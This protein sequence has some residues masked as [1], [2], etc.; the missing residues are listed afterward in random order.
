M[1]EVCIQ[2]G[3]LILQ[4]AFSIFQFTE[5]KI[6]EPFFRAGEGS[7]KRSKNSENIFELFG[8]VVNYNEKQLIQ[9]FFLV[10]HPIPCIVLPMVDCPFRLLD[11][12]GLYIWTQMQ[13]IYALPIVSSHGSPC[14]ETKAHLH[15]M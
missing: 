7:V 3:E 9:N 4:G 14:M 8:S 5:L 2:L 15:S 6:V 13:Y 10:G 11:F 1:T 12:L